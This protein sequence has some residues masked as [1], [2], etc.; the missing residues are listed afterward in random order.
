MESRRS[1]RT[2]REKTGQEFIGRLR[3]PAGT[4]INDALIAAA[5]QFDQ[6]DRP[7]M[8]VF[9]TDGLPTIGER[10]AGKIISNFKAAKGR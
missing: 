7:K 3:P 10:D 6:G 9:M 2:P 8:L 5:K 1:A 4:N